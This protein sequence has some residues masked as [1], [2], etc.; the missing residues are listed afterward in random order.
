MLTHPLFGERLVELYKPNFKTRNNKSIATTMAFLQFLLFG[1]LYQ[2]VLQAHI[3][4]RKPPSPISKVKLSS[5]HVG[6]SFHFFLNYI[7]VERVIF[8]HMCGYFS[9]ISTAL[10][11]SSIH[12][13]N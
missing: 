6:Y 12:F 10:P 1:R 9:P 8:V 11:H 2:L 3:I 4:N 5:N 13:S 7:F